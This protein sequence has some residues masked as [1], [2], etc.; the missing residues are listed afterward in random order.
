MTKPVA[1]SL[2]KFT[3]SVQSAVKAAAGKHSKFSLHEPTAVSLG[4]LIWGIPVPDGV[5]SRAT[6]AET[7][8]LASDIASHI[9]QAHPEALEV[10]HR[11]APAG[12][13]LSLGRY[14]ILGIPAISDLIEF[15]P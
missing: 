8:A 13:V 15:G 7:Q 6:L 2:H 10:A 11:A 3:S 4:Y 14:L 5:L 12:A 1:I 9:A